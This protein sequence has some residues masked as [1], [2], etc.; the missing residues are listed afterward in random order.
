MK[1]IAGD[2]FAGLAEQVA[3]ARRADADERLDEVRARHREEGR[4]GFAGDGLGEQRL[5]GARR[6]DQQHALGRGGADG[7]VLAR[8]GQVVADL[9]SSASASPA[10]ATSA[11]VILSLVPLPFLRPLPVNCEKPAMPPAAPPSP[12]RRMNSE[13]R[14]TSSR[15]GIRN[16]TMIV[17]VP[18][19]DC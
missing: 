5:A 10:P 8:I 18:L 1:M 12:P 9:L 19:P 14:Q 13:N 2:D 17:F 15:I 7:Q 11:K 6:T 16:W 4:V 3:H